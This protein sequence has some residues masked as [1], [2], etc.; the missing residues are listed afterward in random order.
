MSDS[1]TLRV[2]TEARALGFAA[3]GIAAANPLPQTRQ[4]MQ[5]RIDA[6]VYSGLPW[7]SDQRALRCTTPELVL[8]GARSI[9]SLAAPYPRDSFPEG[10]GALRGRVA[11]YAWG[12]DYH[13]I[14][15]K[16]LKHLCALL[17]AEAPGSR[18]RPLVDHGPLAERAY[19]ARAGIGWFGKSSNLLLPGAGS[20]V[21]LAEVL[22]TAELEPDIPL[23]KQCGA[24]TRCIDVC[25][26][27][28]LNGGYL[29]DNQ[30]CISYQTIENR[31][32]IPR[33]LRPLIG[34]WLFGCDLCQ[35]ICPVGRSS[36][37]APLPELEAASAEAAAPALIPLLTLDE[38]GFRVRFAGRP[39]LRAKRDGLL[40][41]ACVVLGN[42]GDTAAVPSLIQALHDQAP[43]VRGHAAWALGRLQGSAARQA[44]QSALPQESD[45]WVQEEIIL[46]LADAGNPV[47]QNQSAG[48][49]L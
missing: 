5:E 41:N 12:R 11:R 9:I 27:G 8:S 16:R 30:R 26:T 47:N 23:R 49:A 46:A 35:E 33:E 1:L 13:R 22:T 24:C 45:A 7:L 37:L 36:T 29:I 17:T 4:L 14:L 34:D 28:A 48:T 18:S 21:L 32:A 38:D 10:R 42:L 2:R 25:P 20:W 19:A 43:L 39:L 31:G 44:L 3:C 15:E 6:G 40:R